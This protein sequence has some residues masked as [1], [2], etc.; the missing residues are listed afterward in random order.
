VN[1]GANSGAKRTASITVAGRTV[2][3]TQNS[4]PAC[5][6]TVQ[7]LL[8]K[9]PSDAKTLEITVTTQ[10][11]CKFT[12]TPKASWIKV[13][14]VPQM[15]GGKVSITVEKNKN[16]SRTSAVTVNGTNYIRDVV[17][18]QSGEDDDEDDDD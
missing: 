14:A 18:T 3:I 6:Y 11:H 15:G 9:F 8:L 5:A 16:D 7:P 1:V 10:A 4:A 2:S 17:V 12:V 13:G